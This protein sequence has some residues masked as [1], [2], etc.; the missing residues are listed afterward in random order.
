[1]LAI[2]QAMP[3]AVA[4]QI[5]GPC[6]RRIPL[7]SHVAAADRPARHDTHHTSLARL[8]PI[9]VAGFGVLIAVMHR[10]PTLFLHPRMLAEDVFVFFSEDRL[11]GARAV[12]ESYAGYYLFLPRFVA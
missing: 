3:R 9:A 6:R 8:L 4:A 10:N 5:R 1:M 7:Q 12:F 2:K 11:F